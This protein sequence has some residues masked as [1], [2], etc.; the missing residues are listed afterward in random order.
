[1][2]RPK[3]Q[4]LVAALLVAL[5]STVLSAGPLSDAEIA[6]MVA[7]HN[8]VR[9]R[10]AQAESLRLGGTV[11]IPDLTWDPTTAAV[12]QEWADLLINQNPPKI[13]HRCGDNA[14][15]PPLVPNQCLSNLGE[16]LYLA[17]STGT[18]DQSASTAVESWASE[19][20][21]YNFD[22]NTCAS[23]KVCGHYTQ[24][25]WSSTQ[26]LGCGRAVRTTTDGRTHVIW[27][28]N[29]A[30]PG[31]MIGQRPY[32]VTRG[33]GG[34]LEGKPKEVIQLAA[35]LK[36]TSQKYVSITATKVAYALGGFS[37]VLVTN[38]RHYCW[39]M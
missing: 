5:C 32:S 1:M 22:Q 8:A 4:I 39:I 38:R 23:G 35:S 13:C 31:N 21:H 17:W 30:P 12:A 24:V 28:C 15:T 10:V 37:V 19:Q 33:G 20:Q 2:A 16:N 11:S 7:A 36:F 14:C 3:L 6:A 26:R 27:V 25:V 29:Y 34:N 18:P 9:Q